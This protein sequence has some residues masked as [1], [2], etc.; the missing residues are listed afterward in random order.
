MS[1]HFIPNKPHTNIIDVSDYRYKHGL[2]N[3]TEKRIITRN[4]AIDS[5]YR[6][7]HAMTSS[8][9]FTYIFPEP[10]NNTISLKVASS[11]IPYL[12]YSFSASQKTNEFTMRLYAQPID[13]SS[14]EVNEATIII[15]D[16]NY[17]SSEL[18]LAINNYFANLAKTENNS[19]FMYL[20][21]DIEETSAKS[22]IR[23]KTVNEDTTYNSITLFNEYSDFWFNLDFR[24]QSD[25]K[26]PVYRNAGW[27]LGF[28]QAEYTVVKRTVPLMDYI[29]TNNGRSDYDLYI[30]GESAY[31]NSLNNYLF[32]EI[33]DFQKN[34]PT[35]GYA[36]NCGTSQMSNNIMGR[37]Q[38]V[39]GFNTILTNN[40]SD[41]I[42][43]KREYFGPVRLEK[44]HIRLLNRY[45][46]V[47]DLNGNDFS[48]V[49]EIEQL[50]SQS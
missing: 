25:L 30:R 29:L 37:I 40:S 39:T 28:N 45:G 32:F 42:Y 9:D 11:E 35:N 4:I 7:N 27:M 2:I 50:Y 6:N 8:T 19:L 21:F 5:L 1:N 49:L 34:V 48:F 10:L 13:G 43:K 44:V 12:W 17:G 14:L 26:R 16:G 31:G 36:F 24:V 33:D 22:I 15:P 18:V 20:Y 47:L 46:E 38:I 3:P 23:T 41:G